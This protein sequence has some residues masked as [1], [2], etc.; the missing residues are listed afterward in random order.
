MT[1][2]KMYRRKKRNILNLALKS[3]APSEF[4]L[5]TNRTFESIND[6]VAEFYRA[7]PTQRYAVIP[8]GSLKKIKRL[9]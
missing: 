2:H 9:A 7:N 4:L 6:R 8:Q 1:Y 3:L 5:C